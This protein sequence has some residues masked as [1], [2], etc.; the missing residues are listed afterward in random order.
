MKNYLIVALFFLFGFSVLLK[1]EEK[2]GLMP[3]FGLGR[4]G[5][6]VEI[7]SEKEPVTSYELGVEYT[8]IEEG[9]WKSGSRLGLKNINAD[10]SSLFVTYEVQMNFLTIGQSLSYDISLGEHIFRPV[11]KIDIGAGL[12]NTE[13]DVLGQVS[14]SDDEFLPY[15]GA[16]VGARY[17]MKNWVP[18][19][20]FGYQYAQIDDI[21][22][23]AIE[24]QSSNEVDFSG[25][26][27]SVGLGYLF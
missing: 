21:G 10:A 25:F 11:A 8:W 1:A 26:Y 2:M 5:T 16:S 4:T 9:P 3:Y 22:F 15:I 27:A 24:A 18:F 17:L 6:E 19:I 23:E 14:E 20:E 7:Q 13:T 12:V